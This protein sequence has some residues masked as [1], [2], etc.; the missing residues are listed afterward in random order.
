MGKLFLILT[1]STL[2]LA[3]SSLAAGPS[4]ANGGGHGTVDGTAPF[5][6][7]L[8]PPAERRAPERGDNRR[9]R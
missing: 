2:V 5:S 8:E 6:Q 3:P 4:V 1:V 9:L 7:F